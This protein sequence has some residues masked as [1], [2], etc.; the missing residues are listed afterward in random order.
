[1]WREVAWCEKR[2][3]GAGGVMGERGGG[4]MTA[5]SG[6]GFGEWER[7]GWHSQIC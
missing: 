4:D 6:L 5:Q 7:E 3:A 1:M 2:A